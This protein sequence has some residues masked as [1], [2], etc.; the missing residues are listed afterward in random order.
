MGKAQLQAINLAEH[1]T[2]FRKQNDEAE[3][4]ILLFSA[5]TKMS[6]FI[7]LNVVQKLPHR[8]ESLSCR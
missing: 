1:T 2:P 7:S 4:N 5:S 6:C 3:L 8:N